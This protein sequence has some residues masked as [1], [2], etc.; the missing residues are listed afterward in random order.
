MTMTIQKCGSLCFWG[1]W[2]GR[3]MDDWHTPVGADYDER[4]DILTICFEGGNRCTVY[5]PKKIVNEPKTFQIQSARKVVWEWYHYGKEQM[6]EYLYRRIYSWN[7][8]KPDLVEYR[9]EQIVRRKRIDWKGEPAVA[10]C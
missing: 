8:R 3:P 10:I 9:G 7:D 1:D 4:R 5:G 2:F 6:P